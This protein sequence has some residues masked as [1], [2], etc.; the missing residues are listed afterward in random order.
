[1]VLKL[2]NEDKG[3]KKKRETSDRERRQHREDQDGRD[4]HEDLR[5]CRPVWGLLLICSLTLD[6][7]LNF[8]VPLFPQMEPAQGGLLSFI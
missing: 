6:A 5:L 7:S 1:M 4:F 3:R 8:S 2:T